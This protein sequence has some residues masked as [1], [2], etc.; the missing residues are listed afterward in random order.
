MGFFDIFK[1]KKV[2]ESSEVV[3]TPEVAQQI[4]QEEKQEQESERKKAEFIEELEDM[5]G[6]ENPKAFMSLK[7]EM[8]AWQ[9]E[10]GDIT[11]IPD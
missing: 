1:K 8:E 3:A 5:E 6:I 4:E 7:E 10:T 11:I 2:E 9:R